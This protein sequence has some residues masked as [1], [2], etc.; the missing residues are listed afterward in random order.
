MSML[1]SAELHQKEFFWTWGFLISVIYNPGFGELFFFC[2]WGVLDKLRTGY[3][4]VE[5]RGDDFLYADCLSE[6]TDTTDDQSGSRL[7]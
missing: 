7:L 3:G 2:V 1:A 4:F 5:A 6:N